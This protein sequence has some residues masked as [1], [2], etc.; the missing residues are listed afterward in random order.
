[1]TLRL[2]VQSALAAARPRKTVQTGTLALSRGANRRPDTNWASRPAPSSRPI[3]EDAD[4][5][6]EVP[7]ASSPPNGMS[8]V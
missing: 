3:T 8:A 4:A 1:M 6:G 2:T 5:N 7:T